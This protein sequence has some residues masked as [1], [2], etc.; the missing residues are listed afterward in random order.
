MRARVGV[1]GGVAE[2]TR[3]GL[4]ARLAVCRPS[5]LWRV[6]RVVYCASSVGVVSDLGGAL[7]GEA[8]QAY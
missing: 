6:E 4:D 2:A 8:P 1:D 5:D 3:Q 7:M